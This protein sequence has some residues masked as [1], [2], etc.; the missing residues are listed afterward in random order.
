MGFVLNFIFKKGKSVIDIGE[1]SPALTGENTGG[2][3][4][5]EC[6]FCTSGRAWLTSLTVSACFLSNAWSPVGHKP[7]WFGPGQGD[8]VPMVL[9]GAPSAKPLPVGWQGSRQLLE[10][11]MTHTV[12]PADLRNNL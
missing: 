10:L 12:I 6:D 8:A 7:L 4:L 1:K 11:L 2:L 9:S 5:K 3:G